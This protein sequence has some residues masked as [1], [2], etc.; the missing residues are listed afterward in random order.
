VRRNLASGR[1]SAD[2]EAVAWGDRSLSRAIDSDSVLMLCARNAAIDADCLRLLAEEALRR[3]DVAS[4]EAA[5]AACDCE[6]T[7]AEG[8]DGSRADRDEPLKELRDRLA[9]GLAAAREGEQS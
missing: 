2:V 8:S 1:S 3:R 4:Y 6:L 9:L 5:L 7:R